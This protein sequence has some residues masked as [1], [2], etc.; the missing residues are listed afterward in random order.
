[1]KELITGLSEEEITQAQ[2]LPY[3]F[4][5]FVHK[6]GAGRQFKEIDQVSDSP[7]G[8]IRPGVYRTPDTRF[9]NL[10]GYQ[11]EPHYAEI[12]QFRMHYLDEGKR[13]DDTVLM[14]H[15]EPTWSYLYRRMVNP[16]VAAWH[17]VLAPDLIGF[18]RSD[19]PASI[20]TH[21]YAFHV[22]AV[23]ALLRQLDL[24]NITLVCQDWGSLIGLRVAAQCPERFAR[25]LVANGGLPNGDSPL[26]YGFQAWRA[27]VVR[28]RQKMDMDVGRVMSGSLGAADLPPET[29]AAYD[30]PFPDRRFKAGPLALPLLV[31]ISPDD[32]AAAA[33]KPFL[34]AFSDG[35]PITRG[36][37]NIF[38]RLVPGAANQRH[39]TIAGAG[40]F[41]QEEKGEE[42]AAV[43]NQFIQDNPL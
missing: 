1:M 36:G 18:G 25:V 38:Q 4:A 28:M 11:Y 39:T 32:P 27:S 31:P 24:N 26:S 15:G 21:S 17:R 29:I 8:E 9:D 22:E 14:L 13:S 41:L 7:Q 5:P 19:K 2:G 3:R 6:V 33:N 20:E 16:V 12:G 30:A 43:V 40:H 10:P 42:L 37:D 23:K 35:D 34:T